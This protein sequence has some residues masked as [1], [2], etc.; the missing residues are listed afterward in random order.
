MLLFGGALFGTSAR[1][2]C[3]PPFNLRT[4][5]ATLDG[6]TFD[7]TVDNAPAETAW[8]ISVLPLGAAPPLPGDTPTHPNVTSKP[9]TITGLAPGTAYRLYIRARCGSAGAWSPAPGTGITQLSGTNGCGLDLP[10]PNDACHPFELIVTNAPGSALGTDVTLDRVGLIV[11]HEWAADLDIYLQAPDGTRV[12]L[13]AD[14]GSGQNNYGDPTDT[15][16]TQRTLFLAP[17]YPG[18]CALPGIDGAQAPF[19]G[20]FLPEESLAAFRSGGAPNGTWLLEICDDAPDHFGTLRHVALDF[21]ATAC[22]PP[23]DLRVVVA[24]SNRLELDWRAGSDCATTLVEYGPPGFVPGTG[25]TPGPQGTVQPLGCPTA[26]V[27]G[28]SPDSIY[29]IYLR[30]DCGNGT[31]TANSCVLRAVTGCSPGAVTLGTTFD[32]EVLCDP[33]C[34]VACP[35]A[36]PWQN[37]ATDQYD[38]VVHNDSTPSANTG[39]PGGAGGGGRYLYLESSA[40]ACQQ[41]RRA[42]LLSPCVD[43]VANNQGCDF[44]FD[45]YRVGTAINRLLLELTTDG[46]LSWTVL[47][48]LRG[49]GPARWERHYVDL[50][51]YD[52][53]T[54]Q[55]RFTGRGGNSATGDIGLD[56]LL[57]YGS[58]DAGAP[59]TY[60]R[61]ADGDGYGVDG[62]TLTSCGAAPAGFSALGGDC[63]DDLFGGQLVNPGMPEIPC[64]NVDNNCNG[65]ADDALLPPPTAAGLTTCAGPATLSAQGVTSFGQL[66]WYAT[67]TGNELLFTGGDFMLTATA[68]DTVRVDTYYVEEVVVFGGTEFCA[69]TARRAVPLTVLPTPRIQAVPTVNICAGAPLDLRNLPLQSSGSPFD[70]LR[71][72]SAFPPSATN[73]LIDP[74]RFPTADGLIYLEAVNANGCRDTS[75]V[76]VALL[77]TPAPQIVGVDTTCSQVAQVLTVADPSGGS[78]YTYQWSTGA[79]AAAIPVF[80]PGTAGGSQPYSVTV[81]APSGCAASADFVLHSAPVIDGFDRVITPVGDCNGSSGSIALQLQGG[82]GPFTYAWSGPASGSVETGAVYTIDDLPQGLYTI[83]ITDSSPFG[84]AFVIP[85]NAVGGPSA[86]I[87]GVSS[88]LPSCAA[89]AD[90]CLTVDISSG[91]PDFQ[92]S[93]GDTT[94][95]ACNLPAGNYSVTV[96]QGGCI[97]VLDQLL[98]DAPVPL[99]SQLTRTGPGCAGGS[100]GQISVSPSGG[101]GP[102]TLT[103]ADGSSGLTRT[104]LAAG[105]Y[106]ATLTDAQGCTLALAPITLTEPAPLLTALFASRPVSCAGDA[107]GQLQVS[108]A[109]GTPPYTYQWADGATAG[110]RDQLPPGTYALT[111]TDARGCT[112]DTSFALLAPP[113]LSVDLFH[114]DPTC[115][116]VDDGQLFA[117]VDGGSGS[118]TFAWN[119]GADAATL[120]NL[121]SGNYSLTVTDARGCSLTRSDSLTAPAALD[122]TSLSTAPSCTG[123]DDGSI[124]LQASGGAGGYTYSWAGGGPDAP[125]F[126][127]LGAGDYAVTVSDANGCLVRDSLSLVAD[128][129]F[130]FT[131]VPIDPNCAGETSGRILV[132][133]AGGTPNYTFTW[134]TGAT[135]EDLLQVTAGDYQL[136]ATDAQGCIFRSDTFT[137]SAPPALVVETVSVDSLSCTSGNVGM[138]DVA[139]SG[140]AGGYTY[141]WNTG[142]TT[143]D[144]AGIGPGTY[145]LRVRDADACF[146]TGDTIV[147]TDYP[148]LDVRFN[149]ADDPN[150]PCSASTVDTITLLPLNGGAP[151]Q[152]LWSDG[153]TSRVRT[154]LQPGEYE[155][156]VTDGRGCVDTVGPIKV[157]DAVFSLQATVLAPPDTLAACL[158]SYTLRAVIDGGTAPFQYNW[159][160]GQAATDWPAD[161]IF[162]T[163]VE[164]GN[165]RLTVTDAVGCVTVTTAAAVTFAD[166]LQVASEVTPILCFGGATGEISVLPS[167]GTAPYTYRWLFPDGDTIVAGSQLDFLAPGSYRVLVE[168]AAG[169]VRTTN[170]LDISQPPTPLALAQ[171]IAIEPVACK[172]GG[173]GNLSAAA[174]GGAPPYTYE[175]TRLDGPTPVVVG[176]DQLLA[177]QPAGEYRLRLLDANGCVLLTN[178]VF[179][180]EPAEALR[181]DSTAL[182]DPTCR[183][184]TDGAITLFP[185]GGW[186]DYTITWL[187]NNTPSTHPATGLGAGI[188]QAQLTD[189]EGCT[190]ISPFLILEPGDSILLT[191]DLTPPADGAA[192]GTITVHATGGLAPYTYA[193]ADDATRTD[194]LRTELV[195]GNYTVT[196]TDAQGCTTVLTITL[197]PLTTVADA[198]LVR[199]LHIGPN[200][201]AAALRVSWELQ[202]PLPLTLALH[203]ATGRRLYQRTLDPATVGTTT[204]SLTTYPVGTYWLTG[205]GPGGLLFR[206]RIVRQ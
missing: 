177:F 105:S 52:G 67:A 13:A 163:V 118:Y 17:D 130:N 27:T 166:P 53:Q 65:I 33:T 161:T 127:G 162:G 152:Y 132:Q 156:T 80:A 29:D 26:S 38:W 44:S 167:G 95:Q 164:S 15:T 104:D 144:L 201:T 181:I 62:L 8:D 76:S 5:A 91:N 100:D 141:Q 49:P 185:G 82:Q 18:A 47:S 182:A 148:P 59:V 11:E 158:D 175:W 153:D 129:P 191:T 174:T 28:L 96:S 204:L 24:D 184:A 88:T 116:G 87:G 97:T 21:N 69:S 196:V 135:T 197:S 171:P 2:A 78:G 85:N 22:V 169:C 183:G 190:R 159:S 71:F 93:T 19:I 79:Q 9:Y 58:T 10:V 23:A 109:G 206:R 75:V 155:V 138:I 64:D 146:A 25:L 202:A 108:S 12:R 124:S 126:D 117:V 192:N 70:T 123:V 50:S 114:T 66:R 193:W 30:A 111:T 160:M 31:Y 54:V 168:D 89:S 68:D 92:W 140:G 98:L 136:T 189:A 147:L 94:A 165:Y 121:P 139:V 63:R 99:A 107:D 34:G 119:T 73:R 57:F 205:R 195:S 40:P 14:N 43:V 46:G 86:V 194:S 200:P 110:L 72:Y 106:T 32:A 6:F 187:G 48:D 188:Y 84:C 4:T 137:L 134:N 176:N 36:G 16:C 74:I 172:G 7:W 120:A 179:L 178:S 1:A 157:P 170:L 112:F 145:V 154:Q 142:A 60:Y 20:E 101:T 128:D 81:T 186:G 39:P 61:D 90:G 149:E 51:A 77:D 151:Y 102:Y 125:Q 56:N 173:N 143:Q 37:V 122:L 83:S 115:V 133:P 45:T 198:D 103:W 113:P 41:G 199:A 3:D 55:L 131:F 35:L 180:D 42:V 203:D 150:D